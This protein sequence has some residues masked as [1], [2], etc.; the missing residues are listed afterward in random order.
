[1]EHICQKKFGVIAQSQINEM[2]ENRTKS[3]TGG[4]GDVLFAAPNAK[5]RKGFK[6]KGEFYYL[7]L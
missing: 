1:M 5:Y 6:E 4:K 2:E 7:L 3:R